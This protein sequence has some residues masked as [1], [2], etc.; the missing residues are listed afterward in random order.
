MRNASGVVIKF[1]AACLEKGARNILCKVVE[2][3]GKCRIDSALLEQ[4]RAA[5]VAGFEL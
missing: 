2:K 5:L 1:V 4:H 3:S